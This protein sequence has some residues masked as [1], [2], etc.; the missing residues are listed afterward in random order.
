V[1]ERGTASLTEAARE[2]GLPPSTAFRLLRTLEAQEFIR[3]DDEGNYR[4][5]ARIV[6]VGAQALGSQ[7]IVALGQSELDLIARETGESA[8]LSLPSQGRQAILAGLAPGTHEIRH[9]S[10]IGRT[11]SLEGTAVGAALSGEVDRRRFANLIRVTSPG[12]TSIASP[13]HSYA[14]VVAALSVVVP[15]FRA[16]P[17]YLERVGRIVAEASDRLAVQL[18][19]LPLG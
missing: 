17:E 10:W 2:V 11:V 14:R 1:C 18:G 8:Y 13:V 5:G 15:N 12:T 7:N 4:A 9:V 3:R 19:A 6:R 16:E